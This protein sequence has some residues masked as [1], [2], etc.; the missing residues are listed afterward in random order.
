MFPVPS[1]PKALGVENK[2]VRIWEKEKFTSG[3]DNQE[4]IGIVGEI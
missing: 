4:N 3:W 2:Y 1:A